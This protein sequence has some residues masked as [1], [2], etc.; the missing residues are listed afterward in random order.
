MSSI[1]SPALNV[2][3]Q[4]CVLRPLDS[5]FAR[6]SSPLFK[7]DDDD[8][9][10]LASFPS[11]F[12][13]QLRLADQR[14]A[15]T[16][17]KFPDIARPLETPLA[18]RKVQQKERVRKSTEKFFLESDQL[19][20]GEEARAKSE[21]SSDNKKRRLDA[22]VSA[23]DSE[24]RLENTTEAA[25]QTVPVRK[26]KEVKKLSV[27]QSVIASLTKE[28]KRLFLNQEPGESDW[29]YLSQTAEGVIHIP[30]LENMKS[31]RK[32]IY[33][34][35]KIQKRE[36]TIEIL[37]GQIGKTG[38]LV[39]SRINSYIRTLNSKGKTSNFIRDVRSHPTS[40]RFGILYELSAEQVLDRFEI[41]FIHIKKQKYP[42]F[43]KNRGG[44][45]GSSRSEERATAY[46]IPNHGFITPKKRYTAK[47]GDKG[48]IRF[49]YTPGFHETLK[50]VERE[51]DF[52]QSTV[53]SILQISTGRRY[54]G[55]SGDI[56]KRGLQHCYFAEY[57]F[58]ESHKYDLSVKLS[59][60]LHKAMGANPSDFS[61]GILPVHYKE[62]VHLSPAS[63]KKVVKVLTVGEA[64]KLII[65]A[66]GTLAPH[67][68]NLHIGGNGSIKRQFSPLT[69]SEPDSLGI[70]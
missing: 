16:S 29:V 22:D 32:V 24:N 54:I 31:M 62:P 10:V 52:W 9:F 20:K 51:K 45:G 18:P 2:S 53:Y 50:Q 37:G 27:A 44:G 42:I 5:G 19:D 68:F 47:V 55:T 63:K 61:I 43:N 21:A 57:A 11:D 8:S 26:T 4:D 33:I 48:K 23:L 28:E 14:F 7:D 1:V 12:E 65:K 6:D 60:I 64:E 25:L 70:S 15:L 35:Q 34:F 40:Y 39:S 38:D 66:T 3:V 41:G 56:A 17:T 36:E 59:G 69:V 58:P 30:L 13:D 67:G 46:Y 49:Q